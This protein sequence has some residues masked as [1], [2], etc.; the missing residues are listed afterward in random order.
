MFENG[1]TRA[2]DKNFSLFLENQTRS[3]HAIGAFFTG[4]KVSLSRGWCCCCCWLL[5]L[6]LL[7]AFKSSGSQSYWETREKEKVM[8]LEQL[9]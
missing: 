5:L 9:E 1:S 4:Q 6:L 3:H 8:L 2:N 7:L